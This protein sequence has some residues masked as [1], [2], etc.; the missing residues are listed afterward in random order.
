MVINNC[1]MWL[2][3]EEL[4]I[5]GKISSNLSRYECQRKNKVGDNDREYWRSSET[6][7]SAAALERQLSLKR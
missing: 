7:D 1:R 2:V 3:V 5:N 4:K 6:G